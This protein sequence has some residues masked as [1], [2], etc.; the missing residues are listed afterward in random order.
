MRVFQRHN[1]KMI[2][3]YPLI[4]SILVPAQLLVYPH[5]HLILVHIQFL[6]YPLIL[7]ILVQKMHFPKFGIWLKIC[8]ITS[9]Q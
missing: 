6:V 4:L 1:D 2:L 7:S 8:Y 9:K 3:V 5:I